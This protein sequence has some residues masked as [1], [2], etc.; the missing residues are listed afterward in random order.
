MYRLAFISG[1]TS[2]IGQATAELLAQKGVSIILNGRRQER[3]D[4]IKDQLSKYKVDIHLA[5]FDIR[6]QKSVIDWLQNHRDVISQVDVLVN[7]AGLARGTDPAHKAIW[8]DWE[9]MLDTNVKALLFLTHQFLPFLQKQKQAHIFNI[10]SVAGRWTYPGGAV[11]SATKFAVRALTEGLRMDLAGLPIRVTNI[12]PGMVETEFSE[13]RFRD[14]EKA[15]TIYKGM[16]PLVAKD[17]AESII[18]ILERP[19]H[20][21]VQELVIF[22]TDQ[23]SIRDVNRK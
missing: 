17:I 22:P 12:E 15:K 20:V 9:E 4:K 2:G 1:A 5:A 13:V 19:T 16:K 10:G 7:N 3:L 11:Y 21:N 6:D 8:S 14:S 18:W 23:A